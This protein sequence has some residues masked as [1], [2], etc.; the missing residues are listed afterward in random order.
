MDKQL[1]DNNES[2]ASG[3]IM[4]VIGLA[5]LAWNFGRIPQFA[6]IEM[7]FLPAL[8]ALFT[9]AGIITRKAGL[10]VPGGIITGVGLGA[11]AETNTFDWLLLS[12]LPEGV[13]FMLTFAIGWVSITAFTALFSDETQWWALIPATIFMLVGGSIMYGG[14]FQSVL[15][16]AG[17]MWPM[18]LIFI[19]IKVFFEG[20][21]GRG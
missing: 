21:R 18:I 13:P 5:A 10:F 6:N 15:V 17:K 1:K 9:L 19:G 4:L 7:L 20:N 16:T 3:V 8:G 12:D 2:A 14:I 11:I